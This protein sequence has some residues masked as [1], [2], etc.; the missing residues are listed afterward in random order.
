MRGGVHYKVLKDNTTVCATRIANDNTASEVDIPETVTH[1]DELFTVV[2]F[3]G[4]WSEE[5]HVQ[6]IK[7]PNTV[8]KINS[9]A[10]SGNNK[11]TD[12]YIPSS[13]TTID[14]NFGSVATHF[15]K[16]HVDENN[17][18][19]KSDDNG[20]LYSADK[21]VLYAVPSSIAL[22][23]GKYTL[24]EGVTTVYSEVLAGISGLKTIGIPASLEHINDGAFT[25]PN[26]KEVAAIEVAAGNTHFKVEHGALVM[27]NAIDNNADTLIYYPIAYQGD[28]F[29]VPDDVTV[30]TANSIAYNDNIK[31]VDLNK[32]A[33][34]NNGALSNLKNLTTIGIP[35]SVKSLEGITSDC[36]NVST[37]NID[38][39]NDNYKSIDGI[40]FSKD[41]TKLVLYPAKRPNTEYI[42]PE[43]TTT[44]PGGTFNNSPLEKLVVAA[45]VTTLAEGSFGNMPNLT[46]LDFAKGSKLTSL[47]WQNIISLPKLKRLVLPESLEYIDDRGI[48]ECHSLEEIVVPDGCKLK[49]LKS[50]CFSDT[51]ALKK[52]TFEGSTI[53]ETIGDEV[54]QNMTNLE[55][56]TIPATVTSIGNRAFNG[57]SGLKNLTFA[58]GSQVKNLGDACFADCGFESLALPDNIETIGKEAFRDCK[59]MKAVHLSATVKSIDPSAFKGCTGIQAFTVDD[60]NQNFAASQGMLCDKAKTTLKLYPAGLIN[61]E[62]TVI[63]PSIT[64]I[65]DYAF[66]D[67]EN[68]TNVV[69][70]QK[71]SKIGKRA[72]GLDNKLNSI[73]LLC[74]AV[75]QEDNVN[76]KA[77]DMSFDDGSL[78]PGT[79]NMYSNITLYVRKD[80]MDT[81]KSNSFW[82]KFKAIKTSFTVQHP[83]GTTDETDE[84]L[85]LSQK[86]LLLIKTKSKDPVYVAPQ[87]VVNSGDDTESSYKRNVNMID[88]YAFENCDGI[89]EVV[90]KNNIYSLG[91]LAFY[92][93]LK[94]TTTDG[95][96]AYAPES[97]S[98]EDVVFC[99]NKAPEVMMSDYYDLDKAGN[100]YAFSDQQKIYVKKSAINAFKAALDHFKTQIDYKLPFAGITSTYGT[101]A[102]EFDT[103]FSD[104]YKTNNKADVAAFVAGYEHEGTDE[105]GNTVNYVHMTSIDE[106]GGYKTDNENAHGY[107]P[108]NTGVLLM[109]KDNS[110][111]ATPTDFYYTIGEHDSTS[112]TISS[113]LLTPVMKENT[114][115]DAS[116]AAPVYIM[117]KTT[118][119]LVKVTT[120]IANFPTHKAYLKLP[121]STN[122]KAKLQLVFGND[123]TTTAIDD[124]ST[125]HNNDGK[126]YDLN[127]REI[128]Y[129]QHGVFV[130]NNKKVIMK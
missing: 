6:V 52:I 12:F 72:F 87:E 108:A 5:W 127:G 117:Q 120:P 28:T 33:T 23:D 60:N 43:G 107:V 55:S 38:P 98:I 99:G 79:T 53:L 29:T 90:F 82:N 46:E 8:T 48:R 56:F 49:A 121:A 24:P 51:P 18:D 91:A 25:N 101:F 95:V 17:K 105:N 123:N 36:P 78:G 15:P 96:T 26:N 73:T 126:W 4:D 59:Q 68:L 102:R 128:N 45:S 97:T 70:P 39:S 118:G 1:N 124:I 11:L 27:T 35:A 129:P 65:G 22:V 71:V 67:C 13:V 109:V 69:I 21:K 75:I 2:A 113:N 115:V 125:N 3:G 14:K 61:D 30:L 74:D 41:G 32:T 130:H 20:V 110:D 83:G 116:E 58:T 106:N 93:K 50:N 64:A 104:Y 44:I 47:W 34:I 111:K 100:Y 40:V 122:A 119:K 81:Y 84:F 31:T 66:Y 103:D 57:C 63:P 37:Y 7:L 19:F 94:Q 114:T 88:N 9:M 92:T 85:P 62:A 112:Y 54:F 42:I 80:L 89:K 16:F 76:T 10:I 86:G 77:G